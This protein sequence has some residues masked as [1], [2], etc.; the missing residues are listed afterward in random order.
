V[1]GTLARFW[2][3]HDPATRWEE[4][5]RYMIV[6]SVVIN[7]GLMTFNLIPIFPL[8]GSRILTGILSRGWAERYRELDR[9]GPLILL[10]IVVLGI[11]TGVN[12]FGYV[13]SPVINVL[14]HLFTGGVI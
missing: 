8:D 1:F 12:L 4:I 9:F 5:L 2:F 11:V 6:Y 14:G 7:L 13:V 3:V 10:G